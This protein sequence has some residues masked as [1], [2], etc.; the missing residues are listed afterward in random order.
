MF[1]VGA[2]VRRSSSGERSKRQRQRL[3][4]TDSLS[5]LELSDLALD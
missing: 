1:Y 3:Q 2:L 5:G 4:K